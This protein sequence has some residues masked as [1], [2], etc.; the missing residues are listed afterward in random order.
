[1][2]YMNQE[3]ITI[4]EGTKREFTVKKDLETVCGNLVN[5]WLHNKHVKKILKKIAVIDSKNVVSTV[6]LKPTEENIESVKKAKWWE[7]SFKIL[8]TMDF[9][10]AA[11]LIA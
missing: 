7:S 9:N 6:N 3:T 1:M 8:N 5:E 10:E 2:A 4:Y 11:K